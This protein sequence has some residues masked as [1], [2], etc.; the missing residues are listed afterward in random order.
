VIL[1]MSESGMRRDGPTNRLYGEPKWQFMNYGYA[2][3]TNLP[4]GKLTL[5]GLQGSSFP[6]Q[7]F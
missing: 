2:D 4:S 3:L 1:W 6:S 7:W 5:G